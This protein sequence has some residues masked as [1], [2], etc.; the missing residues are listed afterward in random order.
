M[1]LRKIKSKKKKTS[2]NATVMVFNPFA[3][4][5]FIPTSAIGFD[6]LLSENV[7][8]I[9]VG[10]LVEL[11]GDSGV[12]KST[13]MFYMACNQARNSG[14]KVV[15]VDAEMGIKR[16]HI[17]LNNA[18]ELFHPDTEELQEKYSDKLE[19]FLEHAF[20]DGYSMVVLQLNSFTGLDSVTDAV[21]KWTEN[22][23]EALVLVIDSLAFLNTTAELD[24]EQADKVQIG[25]KARAWRRWVVTNKINLTAHGITTWFINHLTT[26]GIG[27]NTFLT[28]EK[29]KDESAG[30]KI[31]KY[32]PDVRILIKE[33][34]KIKDENDNVIGNEAKVSTK[35]NRN[36]ISHRQIIIPLMK[37][38]GPDNARFLKEVLAETG[39]VKFSAWTTFDFPFLEEPEKV[40]GAE[41]ALTWIREHEE[42]ITEYLKSE[43]LLSLVDLGEVVAADDSDDSDTA[44]ELP[45]DEDED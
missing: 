21:Y 8:G 31:S 44:P 30:G 23:D 25:Q 20:G 16:S 5:Q 41:K 18:F 22:H 26:Q 37:G 17:R 3:E 36:N 45:D 38:A 10:S 40:N 15:Y 13:S 39:V 24:A 42:Q 11:N 29:P 28:H 33:G 4:E 2:K 1:A 12:G 7:A 34:S 32:G 14:V 9:E 19:E 35:K 27:G 6:V 43:N